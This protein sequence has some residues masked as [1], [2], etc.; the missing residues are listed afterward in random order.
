MEAWFELHDG[1][2]IVKRA[3]YR[4]EFTDNPKTVRRVQ[5]GGGK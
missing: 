5:S 3:E 1:V 4:E 2:L